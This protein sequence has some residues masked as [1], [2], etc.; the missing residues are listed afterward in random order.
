MKISPAAPRQLRERRGRRWQLVEAESV[1]L[2][3][4]EKKGVK[5][6]TA[7]V[8]Y[9]NIQTRIAANGKIIAPNNRTFV[10]S[11]AFP[12]RVS[13]IIVRVGDWVNDGSPLI[14]LQSEEVGKSRAEFFRAQAD[15]DLA[16]ANFERQKRLFERGAGAQK[17]YLAAEA[18]LKVARA[19]LEACEKKLHLLGFTEEEVKRMAAV[20]QINPI[21]TLYSPIRGKVVEIKVVPGDMV[22][23][24]KDMMTILDPRILWVDAEIF[25]KDIARI[26]LGQKAEIS[27]PAYPEKIFLG[28]VSYIGDVLKEETRTITV[29]TEVENQELLLKPGMFASLKINLNGDKAVL[30]VP[31]AAVC[32]QQG[33]KFVFLPRGEEFELRKVVLGVRQDGYYEVVSGLKEGELVVTTGS[34]QL[35][36]KLLEAIL[37]EA[38]HE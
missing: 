22:D 20:H 32:D 7:P 31:E 9:K 12:A 29:R 16:Q 25:E 36:S 28:K 34:F 21:I 24:A 8:S 18:E 4:N 15:L 3:N 13:N 2:S 14:T 11:Y 1:A 38:I 5:I 30:A 6:E 19:N 23:Q 35:K 26:K 37:K 17:D 10:V 27:V 33:E